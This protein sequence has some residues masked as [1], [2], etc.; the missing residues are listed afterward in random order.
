MILI[1]V[2]V[3]ILRRPKL[4]KYLRSVCSA[5]I[6]N[7]PRNNFRLEK[8]DYN[9]VEIKPNYNKYWIYVEEKIKIPLLARFLTLI[10]WNSQYIFIVDLIQG[11]SFTLILRAANLMINSLEITQNEGNT[12]I[13]VDIM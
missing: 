6:K 10:H 3:I 11:S 5:F 8:T 1:L 2:L 9:V 13:R 7:V 4:E 12:S